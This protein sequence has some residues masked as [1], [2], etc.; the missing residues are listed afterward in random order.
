M[1]T[2]SLAEALSLMSK[3]GDVSRELMN[4]SDI[5]FA[6]EISKSELLNEC[7]SLSFKISNESGNKIS[8]LVVKSDKIESMHIKCYFDGVMTVNAPLAHFAGLQKL[9][10]LRLRV[11]LKRGPELVELLH[12]LLKPAYRRVPA[13]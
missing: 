10:D 6:G 2:F 7:E 11:S 12:H 13:A 3:I 8:R 5:D 1:K 4:P 9:L